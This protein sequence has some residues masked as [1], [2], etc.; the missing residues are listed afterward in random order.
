MKISVFFILALT[1]L[2]HS[3]SAQKWQ[4][5]MVGVQE[6]NLVYPSDRDMNRIPD[7]GQVG[8]QWGKS[9]IPWVPTKLLIHPVEGDN[10][11]HIQQAIDRLATFARDS[12]GYRGAVQLAPG[13]YEVHGV[14]RLNNSGIVLRGSG[15]GTDPRENSILLAK[16]DR[17]KKRSVILAGGGENT[18]WQGEVPDTKTEITTDFVQVGSFAFE[19]ADASPFRKGDNIIIHHP[20]TRAWMDAIGQQHWALGQYNIRYNRTVTKVEGRR[21]HIDSPVY[22]HLDRSLSRSHIYKYDRKG[23]L[24][25]IGIEDIRVLIEHTDTLENHARNAVSL[26]QIEHSWV[27]NSTFL[28]FVFSGLITETATHIT[29]ENCRAIEPKGLPKG[30][31][32]YNFNAGNASNNILFK[33]C[34]AQGAR[35]AFVANG[36]SSASGIVVYR[37]S[38]KDPLASS[39]GH[40]HWTTGMLFDNFRDYGTLPP[41]EKGRVLGYY[42]RGHYGSY[43]GWTNAHSVLWNSDV[44]RGTGKPGKVVIQRPRTAQNYAIGSFGDISGE[45][46]FPGMEGHLEGIGKPLLQPH[47]LYAA[48][49]QARRAGKVPIFPDQ[50]L[51]E[52]PQRELFDYPLLFKKKLYLKDHGRLLGGYAL[53]NGQGKLVEENE[54]GIA[55]GLGENLSPGI[56]DLKIAVDGRMVERKIIKLE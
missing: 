26:R 42:N 32:F 47:S 24:S 9:P 38:S 49:L 45:G 22:N 28:H 53:Y 19:V 56:Y 11:I 4:S 30:G 20:A 39:E 12:S 34:H 2:S 5:K 25:H 16:G 7:F 15:D 55:G 50:D 54:K 23:V 10:T 18:Q 52:E 36:T 29:V 51:L 40:R 13:I 27:R 21:I 8:Y 46:P 37:C 3:L 35:H 31:R 33:D 44:T 43:H 6:G 17:P 41:K 48:Q 1:L 14:L